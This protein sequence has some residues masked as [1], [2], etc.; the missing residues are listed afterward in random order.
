M[1]IAVQYHVSRVLLLSRHLTSVQ[2]C[3]RISATIV[4]TKLDYLFI[5]IVHDLLDIMVQIIKLSSSFGFEGSSFF[6]WGAFCTEPC[7]L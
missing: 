1:T 7:A 3:K 6:A 4:T 2:Q 5:S